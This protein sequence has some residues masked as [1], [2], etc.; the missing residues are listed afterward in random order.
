MK[1]IKRALSLILALLMVLSLSPAPFALAE[2]PEGTIAPVSEP[3]PEPAAPEDPV[4]DGV[5]D[6]PSDEPAAAPTPDAPQDD[7]HYFITQPQSGSFDPD[8]LKYHCTWTT[9]FKPL[10]VEIRYK[11][12]NTWE[13][14]DSVTSPPASAYYDFPAAYGSQEYYIKAYYGSGTN[15]YVSSD[16]FTVTDESLEF[17]VQP[18]DGSFDPDSQSYLAA[19]QTNFTP[20]RVEILY[21]SFYFEYFDEITAPQ[22]NGSYE[23]PATSGTK[24][25]RI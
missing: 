7:E 18:R 19:W 2:E 14:Y 20:L 23:F 22:A 8:T 11:N 24:E 12:W 15:D 16:Y 10:R 6:V 9:S 4:G 3:S 13:D 21:K 25:Y 5:L 1:T 17:L